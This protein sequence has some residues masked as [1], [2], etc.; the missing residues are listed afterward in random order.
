M[1]RCMCICVDVCKV[2]ALEAGYQAPP[3]ITLCDD[4]CFILWPAVVEVP[5]RLLGHISAGS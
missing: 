1:C 4:M 3:D 2:K 5:F